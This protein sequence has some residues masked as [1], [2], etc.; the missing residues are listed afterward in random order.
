VTFF[1]VNHKHFLLRPHQPGVKGES[2][3][4]EEVRRAVTETIPGWV[5]PIQGGTC[6][7]RSRLGPEPQAEEDDLEKDGVSG[8][9]TKRAARS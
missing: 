5:C 4:H 9:K 1:A 7:W 6:G 2:S 3:L 8:G